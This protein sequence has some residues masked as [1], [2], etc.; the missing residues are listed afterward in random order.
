MF[1]YIKGHLVT[2]TPAHAVVDNNGMGYV[3]QVSL[4]TFEAL[5]GKK[6]VLLYTHLSIREDAHVLF[7]FYSEAERG[8]FRSLISV[9]GIGPASAIAAL[10]TMNPHELQD[11]ILRGDTG[12]LQK[13]KGIGAKSAQ[14]IIVD[15]RD[16]IASN[17][18]N[19][20]I[21]AGQNN[22]NRTEALKALRNLGFDQRKAEK[23]VDEVLNTS[24]ES[25][26]LEDLIKQSLRKL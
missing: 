2:R 11:A 12:S 1:E 14:R 5:G 13:V 22:T 26:R 15:L 25:I 6:E 7:G 8:M 19:I 21:F 23:V 9:S 4:N 18:A 17:D 16:K 24:D 10:S 20:D 3:L